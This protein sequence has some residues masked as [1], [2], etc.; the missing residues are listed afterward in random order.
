MDHIARQLQLGARHTKREEH[1][2]DWFL[3]FKAYQKGEPFK[4]E[5]HFRVES[6]PF[7]PGLSLEEFV[8]LRWGVNLEGHARVNAIM[9]A[10]LSDH[11]AFYFYW[12]W[13]DTFPVVWGGRA[14]DGHVVAVLFTMTWT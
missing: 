7:P 8:K 4:D 14:P 5:G 2:P 3:D 9:K 12:E 11:F 1:Q 10:E 6:G 13:L